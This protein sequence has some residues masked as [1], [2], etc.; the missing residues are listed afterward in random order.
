M[1]AERRDGGGGCSSMGRRAEI[2]LSPLSRA[3]FPIPQAASTAG[4]GM[5]EKHVDILRETKAAKGGG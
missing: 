5:W 1:A 4:G 3:A 2:P